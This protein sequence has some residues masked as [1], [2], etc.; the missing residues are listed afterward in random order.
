M[1]F[2][3]W[4]SKGAKRV[5]ELGA[6]YKQHHTLIERLLTLDTPAAQDELTRAWMTMDDRARGGFKMTLGGLLLGQQATPSS[7]EAK[8]RGERLKAVNALLDT[9]SAAAPAVSASG[10]TEA[11]FTAGAARVATR[12]AGAAERAKPRAAE[13]LEQARK[14]IEQHAP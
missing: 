8:K 10:S 1:A 5:Q 4:I 14:E 11:A 13:I 9:L 6:E 7:P 2:G 3:D 12:L